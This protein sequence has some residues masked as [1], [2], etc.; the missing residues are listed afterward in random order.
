MHFLAAFVML[1]GASAW[2]QGVEAAPKP[3]WPDSPYSD[4]DRDRAVE[5]GV[6]FLYRFASDPESFTRW[7]SDLLWCFYSISA[8]SAN[9]RLREMARAMGYERA[10][11]WRRSHPGPPQDGPGGLSE[12][13]HGDLAAAGLG[14]PGEA[15]R[16]QVRVAAARYRTVDFLGFDPACEPPPADLP[17]D[18]RHCGSRNPRGAVRCARCNAA[19][20][21]KSRYE[22]WLDALILTYRG[23]KCG[24][25]LGAAY[26]DVL[27]WIGRMRPYP[28]PN[29]PA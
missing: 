29:R 3:L 8:T 19:L 18:C 26:A 5:R 6:G 24:V 17:E 25:P 14:V 13:V 1:I 4:A 28:S 23:D 11:Q 27:R 2:A 12:F 15:V 10:V 20:K 7:D 22:V 9:V 21:F 16:D